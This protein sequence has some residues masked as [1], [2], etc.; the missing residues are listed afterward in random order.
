MQIVKGPARGSLVGNHI[1]MGEVY[2]ECSAR[3]ASQ[4]RRFPP[5]W[6]VEEL[7][8]CFVVID[9]LL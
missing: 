9:V 7:N 5:P 1:I 6:S 2:D 3:P 4:P 8:P